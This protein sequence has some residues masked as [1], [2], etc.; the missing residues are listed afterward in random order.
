M[1]D[2]ELQQQTD[3]SENEGLETGTPEEPLESGVGEKRKKNV[4]GLTQMKSVIKDRNA[5]R[6]QEILYNE[7][8]QPYGAANTKLQSYVGVLT[9]ADVRVSTPSWKKV[10]PTVKEKIWHVIN[11]SCF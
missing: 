3:D 4:R 7:Y 1:D 8:G 6:I 11:V 9:R 2:D 10:D 5:G